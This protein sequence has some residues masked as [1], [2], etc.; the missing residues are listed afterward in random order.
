[1]RRAPAWRR[2]DGSRRP[3]HH[4]AEAVACPRRAR[5]QPGRPTS[6]G[7]PSRPEAPA[8]WPEHSDIRARSSF[9]YPA[10][11]PVIPSLAVTDLPNRQGLCLRNSSGRMPRTS[12]K[13]P[14]SPDLPDLAANPTCISVPAIALGVSRR[15]RASLGV[16]A[17]ATGRRGATRR[18]ILS[19]DRRAPPSAGRRSRGK[20]LVMLPLGTGRAGIAPG[21]LA[22][23]GH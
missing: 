10:F 7:K 12:H 20:G 11:S 4:E 9:A 5:R 17:Q 15:F 21:T 13:M 23:P 8:N 18:L 16:R 3:G 22:E 14:I 1:M 2:P 6:Q 19:R